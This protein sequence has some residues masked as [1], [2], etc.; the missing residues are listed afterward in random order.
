MIGKYF[1]RKTIIISMAVISP[2]L[3][4]A[5]ASDDDIGRNSTRLS[6][7]GVG[8]DTEP[9]KMFY[10]RAGVENF[11]TNPS[12]AVSENATKMAQLRRRLASYGVSEKDFATSNFSFRPGRQ[13]QPRGEDDLKGFEV[14][15]SLTV[16]FRRPEKTGPILDALVKA[17]ATNIDGPN[18]SWEASPEASA[19]ARADAIRDA[20]DKANIYAKALGMRVKRIV[21]INDGSGYRSRR[22]PAMMAF[23]VAPT[24]IDPGQ[25]DVTVSVNAV[26]ELA[27]S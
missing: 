19:R 21:S 5:V 24:R 14:H 13:D 15:H 12:D 18:M 25:A 26:F 2:V 17:G 1:N 16:A 23:D 3:I 10:V 22:A 20:M 4:G 11:S 9:V 8:I 6:L 7:N 27:K